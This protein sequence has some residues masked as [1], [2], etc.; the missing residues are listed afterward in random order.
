MIFDKLHIQTVEVPFH[1]VDAGRVLY[2]ANY[3]ILFDQARS[4]AL[5]QAGYPAAELWNDGFALALVESTSRY[6]RP[7]ALGQKI[8]ILTTTV[9]ATG[10]SLKVRQHMVPSSALPDGFYP[11]AALAPNE[12][13]RLHT[14]ELTLVCV[15]LEPLRPARIPARLVEALNIAAARLLHG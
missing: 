7:A 15:K 4:Q 3:L 11:A 5:R 2:H 8:S 12:K 9:A 13:T 10:S 14:A 1:L 6:F